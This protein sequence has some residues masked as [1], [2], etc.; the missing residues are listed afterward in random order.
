[1]MRAQVMKRRSPPHWQPTELQSSPAHRRAEHT[2]MCR[3]S[4][5]PLAGGE[6]LCLRGSGLCLRVQYAA[7]MGRRLPT[8]AHCAEAP[9]D[10]HDPHNLPAHRSC[11]FVHGTVTQGA[12]AAQAIR[13]HASPEALS[14]ERESLCQRLVLL[15]LRSLSLSASGFEAVPLAAK[16]TTCSRDSAV[17]RNCSLASCIPGAPLAY[18]PLPRRAKNR[19]VPSSS[20]QPSSAVHRRRC[21][22]RLPAR[23]TRCDTLLALPCCPAGTQSEKLAALAKESR[24]P[25]PPPPAS[26]L[27]VRLP[28][29]GL[30]KPVRIGGSGGIWKWVGAAAELSCC[31]HRAVH[32][33]RGQG[34]PG[35]V[36]RSCFAQ[37]DRILP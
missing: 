22:T 24:P 19:S 5:T 29:M 6:N 15:S 37:S 23:S 32:C 14:A 33:G 30:P 1:M 10:A 17:A 26:L 25:G 21:C 12:V 11:L 34:G 36:L 7:A 35:P 16:W 4:M 31:A 9:E 28:L 13:S 3:C 8:L 20:M 18:V 2:Q 27:G